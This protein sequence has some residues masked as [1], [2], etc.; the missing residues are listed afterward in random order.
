MAVAPAPVATR[1]R[2]TR[3]TSRATRVIRSGTR[4]ARGRTTS[5]VA[6]IR[7]GAARQPQ[8]V[9]HPADGVQEA[10]LGGVDLAAEVGDVGLDHVGLAVEVV[11][12]HV[13]ENLRLG[14]H[15]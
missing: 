8:G 1:A 14:E 3:T 15:P 5:S 13:V 4:E 2:A 7:S 10:R 12:P 6:L 9:A 11:V